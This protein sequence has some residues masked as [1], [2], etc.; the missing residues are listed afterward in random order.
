MTGGNG[1]SR[2]GGGRGGRRHF[3]RPRAPRRA[4]PAAV[5]QVRACIVYIYM[6]VGVGGSGGA[7]VP[8]PFFETSVSSRWVCVDD[9]D[10]AF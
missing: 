7:E 3:G 8:S 9:D 10:G 1:Q 4:P 5:G 2:G 6:D